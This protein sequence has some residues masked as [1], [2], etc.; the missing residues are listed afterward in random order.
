MVVRSANWRMYY[1]IEKKMARDTD[2]LITINQ[3]DL[4]AKKDFACP[5]KMIDGVGVD[6]A[7]FKKTTKAEQASGAKTVWHCAR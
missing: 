3:E 7:K 5:V 4:R 2:L 1:P 6:M